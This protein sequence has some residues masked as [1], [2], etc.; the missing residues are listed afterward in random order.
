MYDTIFLIQIHSRLNSN[1]QATYRVTIVPI[2][3]L[4]L[5]IHFKRT[6]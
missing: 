1:L 2:V 4:I 5:K 3:S 6:S